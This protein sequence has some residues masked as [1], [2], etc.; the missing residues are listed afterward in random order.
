MKKRLF[1][2]L[3]LTALFFF[4]MTGVSAKTPLC[5]VAMNDTVPLYFTDGA[6]P[7]YNNGKLYLPYTAFRVNPNSVGASYN[8]EKGTFVLFN[9]SEMLIFDLENETY[10][11]SRDQVYSVDLAYRSGL[12]Y[13]PAS[14]AKHFGLSVTMLTS[15]AGYPIIRFTNGEQV[16]DDGM[17]VAQAENLINH[18]AQQVEN[19]TTAQDPNLGNEPDN[20]GTL[21]PEETGPVEIYMAFTG[22]A[23]SMETVQAL[24]EN[25]LRAAFFLTEQQFLLERDLVRA[26]YAG[27][28][29]IGLTADSEEPELQEALDRAND[30]MDAVLFCRSVYA[31]LPADSGQVE[32]Y[33]VLREPEITLTVEEMQEHP[34]VPHLYIV[35][36]GAPDV[37]AAFAATGATLP[38]LLETT[39]V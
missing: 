39:F 25:G 28:H 1:G 23:V 11:D 2:I 21:P 10:T 31:L 29:T 15:R 7:Y 6:A 34:E 33:H 17:F 12:L 18:V 3:L 20:P 4:T 19:E 13:V 14:V 26:I 38:Q 16:Y 22:E 30:A 32:T 5:F 36:F 8:A 37:I 24:E 35:R 27:G 9:G